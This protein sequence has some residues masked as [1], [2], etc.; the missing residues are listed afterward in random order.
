[1]R[2][3]STL[4][5]FYLRNISFKT[6]GGERLAIVGRTGAG[7]SSIG[8][9]CL[10]ILEAQEGNIL[11]D[12]QDISE[13]GLHEL[14]NV[15][16]IIPQDPVLFTGSLRENI[17]PTGEKLDFDIF[18]LLKTANLE[19]YDDLDLEEED[20]RGGDARTVIYTDTFLYMRMTGW[21]TCREHFS[22]S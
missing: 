10:R 4:H 2:F 18:K 17:D 16:T 9:A 15:V 19:K 7:K 1:M 12:M 5:S 22:V 8:L 11:I 21:V 3:K 14:R 20:C 13:L 6:G